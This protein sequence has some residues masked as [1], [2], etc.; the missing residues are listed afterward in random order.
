MSASAKRGVVIMLCAFALLLGALH[1]RSA[2]P[3]ISGAV[4]VAVDIGGPFTLV[5]QFG[6]TRRDSEFRGKLML[7]YF[8]YTQCQELCSTEL[9]T[10]ST[11]LD[12]L[13][14]EQAQVEPLFIT[15]D[16]ARDTPEVLKGFVAAFSPRLLALSG[17]PEQVAEA[18]R[19]YHI[20]TAQVWRSDGSYA[21]DHSSFIYLMGA[22]GKY[23]AHFGMNE[24]PEDIARTIA[25]FL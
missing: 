25:G 24:A 8:G 11:V 15:V 3:K 19:S 5:D 9:Q 6:K 20:Y 16:P 2:R 1:Y 17:T 23:L 21:I 14:R 13:G 22:D 12:A 10:I 4:P 7:V 18:E